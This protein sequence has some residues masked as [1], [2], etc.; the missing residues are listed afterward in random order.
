MWRVLPSPSRSYADYR[1]LPAGAWSPVWRIAHIGAARRSWRLL[2]HLWS[3]CR[4]LTS[5]WARFLVGKR[6]ASA[7][8]RIEAATPHVLLERATTDGILPKI[9]GM[10]RVGVRL[11]IAVVIVLGALTVLAVALTVAPDVA[12]LLP[13]P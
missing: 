3:V 7:A 13:A 1:T 11:G 8:E 4:P 5:R 9:Q 12:L 6:R 2:G 10:N